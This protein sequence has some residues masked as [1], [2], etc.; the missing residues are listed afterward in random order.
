M[1]D[2]VAELEDIEAVR[3]LSP[4]KAGSSGTVAMNAYFHLIMSMGRPAAG[5]RRFVAG[6]SVD[7]LRNDYRRDLRNGSLGTLGAVEADGSVLADFDGSEQR[8]S[9]RDLEDLDYAYAI[10][11]LGSLGLPSIRRP[12][13]HSGEIFVV[14]SCL[15]GR[16]RS[17]RWHAAWKDPGRGPSR[18]ASSQSATEIRNP[19]VR[20]AVTTCGRFPT[21]PRTNPKLTLN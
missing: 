4:L 1:V 13:W 2:A 12:S 14:A 11:V 5:L 20:R 10:T 18:A 6:E 7:F 21:A 16:R 3:I 17:R 9:G 19:G 15:G 8:L